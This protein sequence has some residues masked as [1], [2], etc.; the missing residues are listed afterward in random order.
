MAVVLS[1]VH[2]FE[3]L[4]ERL[5]EGVVEG[6]VGRLVYGVV[7]LVEAVLGVTKTLKRREPLELAELLF[8]YSSHRLLH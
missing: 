7:E 8:V 2:H 6:V 4:V 5:V 3:G 1:G